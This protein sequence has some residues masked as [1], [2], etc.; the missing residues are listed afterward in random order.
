MKY[1]VS[2]VLFGSNGI[3]AGGVA[4]PSSQTV[5]VR[6]FLGSVLLVATLTA[7]LAMGHKRPDHATAHLATL[8]YPKQACALAAS[9]AALGI[10][11]IFLFEAYRLVG[12]GV[13]TLA[14]YCGPA[15]VM[16]LSPLL[17]SER[18]THARVAGFSCVVLGA[19]FVVAQEGGG[20]GVSAQGLALG[21]MST[22]MY[23]AMAVFS[24]RAPQIRGLEAASVQL[25]SCFVA[26]LLY[27]VIS[28]SVVTPAALAQ[29]NLPAML[30]LGFIN[31]GLGCY[32]Y[33]SSIG[34]LPVQRF[35]V[36]GY[37][38]PLSAVVLSA[39]ILG[40]PLT[41]GHI[42]GACLIIGGAA[43][44]E[45]L[46]SRDIRLP[47]PCVPRSRRSLR[48]RFGTRRLVQLS[49]CAK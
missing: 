25:V 20:H 9:G 11:W 34:Q 32:L 39:A 48:P 37:L 1:L 46:G 10:G 16:A 41:L 17:F 31:T 3:V 33:F 23:A 35:A 6:S 44:S 5:L 12:V 4:L 29:A 38:E 13:S 40:E 7:S 19:F 30:L 47:W 36:C 18:L 24:R 14:Y 21:G 28:S 43:A 22:V 42:A 8:E 15:I 26:V 45:L 2:L 49:H 27:S